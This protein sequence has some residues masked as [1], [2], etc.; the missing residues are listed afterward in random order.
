ME[1]L[2]IEGASQTL[3]GFSWKDVTF[4]GMRLRYEGRG[5]EFEEC[6]VCAV[7]VWV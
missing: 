4:V 1:G 2:T 5:Y 6:E 3:D 7:H